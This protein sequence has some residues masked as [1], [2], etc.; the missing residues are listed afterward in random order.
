LAVDP[1]VLLLDEPFGALDAK[2]RRDL[3]RWLRELHDRTGHTT[4]FVTHDQEEA[5][6]LADRV[7]I[8]NTGK[9]EQISTGDEVY[10]KPASPFVMSFVGETSSIRVGF[11]GEQ[12]MYEGRS[13]EVNLAGSYRGAG[14]LYMRPGDVEV[15]PV[16]AGCVS[17]VV[18]SIRRTATGRRIQIA[19]GAADALIE[20]EVNRSIEFNLGD[21]VGLRILRGTLFAA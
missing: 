5:L 7:A 17:G 14:R 19:A 20:A 3:R 12:L 15:V 1:R 2:V 13:F 10:E 4:V 11:D 9:L 6:E 18:K 16:G 8:L 21:Q